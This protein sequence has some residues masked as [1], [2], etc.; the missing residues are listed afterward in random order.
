MVNEDLSKMTYEELKAELQSI[1]ESL[2]S[3]QVSID[4]VTELVRRSRVIVTECQQRLKST[5]EQIDAMIAEVQSS[6]F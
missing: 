2:S 6:D 5:R 1:L 4:N 3:G